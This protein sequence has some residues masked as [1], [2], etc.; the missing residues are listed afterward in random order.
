M[1]DEDIY[2]CRWCGV[3]ST[4]TLCG[5]CTK[6]SH[7][8]CVFCGRPMRRRGWIKLP[9]FINYGGRGYCAVHYE[10]VNKYGDVDALERDLE[11]AVESYWRNRTLVLAGLE[12]NDNDDA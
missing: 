2:R 11:E 10:T 8:N 9:G 5:W 12:R 3:W 4:D 6:M 7:G 1:R